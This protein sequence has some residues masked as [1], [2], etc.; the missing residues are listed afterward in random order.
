M[1]LNFMAYFDMNFQ[2]RQSYLNKWLLNFSVWE[3][4]DQLETRFI[5]SHLLV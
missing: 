3:Y 1:K 4:L 5:R 2:D